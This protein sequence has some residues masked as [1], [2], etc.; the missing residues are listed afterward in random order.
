MSSN[1]RGTRRTWSDPETC[2][3]CGAGLTDAGSGFIDHTK[4]SPACM[5]NF[6]TWRSQV[7]DD[8]GGEWSG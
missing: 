5:S 8:M 2:P 7:A 3:F 4:A 1:V 6:D